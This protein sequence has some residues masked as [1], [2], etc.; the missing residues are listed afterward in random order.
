M[1]PIRLTMAAFGP[2]SGTETIDFTTL[3]QGGIFLVTGPTGAGKTTIFDA[4]CFALYGKASGEERQNENFKS[5]FAPAD[6]LCSVTLDFELRGKRFSI[7]RQ[8]PQQKL[9][10]KGTMTVVP[11]RVE[12]TLPDGDVVSGADANDRV[13][14]ILGINMRQFKQIVMLPQGEFRRLLDASSEEKQ[15]IF[16]RIFST[17]LFDEFAQELSRQTAQLSE[18]IHQQLDAISV[19]AGGLDFSADDTH[20][21]LAQA[22]TPDPEALMTAAAA[23]LKADRSALDTLELQWISVNS[24]RDKLNL[25]N[26]ADTNRKFEMLELLRQKATV[27]FE[28]K[29][30]ILQQK[31]KLEFIRGAQQ[32]SKTEELLTQITRQMDEY[33]VEM[34]DAQERLP[35]LTRLMQKE[36][37]ALVDA[38]NREEQKQVLVVRRAG[39]EQ[40]GEAMQRAA[41]CRGE[42][43]ALGET[44]QTLAAQE[45]RLSGLRGRAAL[46]EEETK[47]K[48]RAALLE[49]MVSLCEQIR[50][51]SEAYLVG[52]DQY[53]TDYDFFLSAQAGILAR[54]L[55]PGLPCPVCGSTQHPAPAHMPADVPSQTELDRMRAELDAMAT[56]I[57]ELEAELRQ[58]HRQL[59]YLTEVLPFPEEACAEHAEDIYRIKAHT[60]DA[61]LRLTQR[62]AAASGELSEPD[63]RYDSEVF[64]L[65]EIAALQARIVKTDAE[66]DAAQRRL[67]ELSELFSAYRG[68]EN[69]LAEELQELTGQ[70]NA[71]DEEISATTQSYIDAKSEYDKLCKTIELARGKL[72]SLGSQKALLKGQFTAEL[73]QNRFTSQE[74]Y[75]EYLAQ[76][77]QADELAHML[78]EYQTACS[79]ATA[80]INT[81]DMALKGKKPVDLAA[82]T[83]QHKELTAE[84]E[85][86]SRRKVELAARIQL[87]TQASEAIRERYSGMAELYA[88]YKDLSELSRLA[89]G[90]NAQRVSF[91]S[92]VLGS[93]FDD[94]IALANL[95]LSRM[96]GA[97]YELRRRAEREKFG[98]SSGLSLEIIDSFSGKAR[99]ISTLS[100]GESFKTSL[101]LALSLADIVQMYAGG[102]SIDTMFIDEGFGSL[103]EESLDFA[104]QTLTSLDDTGRVVGIISHVA[105]LRERIPT[106]LCVHAGRQ[107]SHCDVIA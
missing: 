82:L 70:I 90:N 86:L 25:E 107:G 84:I 6:A 88:R 80:E 105:E 29:D 34:H 15:K 24:S 7:F 27:L 26:A 98:R 32:V 2:F 99:H 85:A 19:C 22:Q 13:V 65:E 16:R 61:A 106:R 44:R 68:G 9:T 14:E 71:I 62:V 17:E 55:E 103:D 97:R 21:A 47:T 89:T 104:V 33:Q 96:T 43:A 60:E 72:F 41:L 92:Y 30:F 66:T 87:N 4:I 63:A 56:E 28:R 50:K 94:I 95:R 49:E 48:K 67:D 12:L 8:P 5:D 64:V 58:R 53:I 40:A 45:K 42:L 36:H 93:Y 79:T 46:L 54:T 76:T 91:E 81:L 78:D 52:K 57:G 11:S 69:S 38:K 10:A 59:N 3:T 37:L 23:L 18:R 74:M 73:N 31:Q 83:E 77:E 1:K 20:A 35:E 102:V 101:A 75:H 51:Q 100:G 39:L